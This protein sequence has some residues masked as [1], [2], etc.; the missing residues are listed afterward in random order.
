MIS[1]LAEKEETET[2][3]NIF[4]CY[5]GAIKQYSSVSCKKENCFFTF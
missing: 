1:S 5:L 2:T 4:T 3:W